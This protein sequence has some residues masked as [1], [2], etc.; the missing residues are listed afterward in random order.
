MHQNKPSIT[1]GNATYF[2]VHKNENKK[3][4]SSMEFHQQQQKHCRIC[5]SRL[6]KAKGRQQPVYSACWWH[7]SLCWSHDCLY[8]RLC[9]V[10]PVVLQP[11]PTPCSIELRRRDYPSIPS[12]TGMVTTSGRLQSRLNKKI[13]SNDCI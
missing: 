13:H 1:L 5:G 9:R 2:C 12:C 6:N 10:S 8:S 11:V 3:L 4:A 7:C